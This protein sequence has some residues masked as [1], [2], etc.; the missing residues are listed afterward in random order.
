MA[1][2]A[3]DE[4]HPWDGLA[5]VLEEIQLARTL[6]FADLH[7]ARQAAERGLARLRPLQTNDAPHDA[8]EAELRLLL[9]SCDRQ[10]GHLESAVRQ[11]HAALKLLAGRWGAPVACE[12]WIGLG[13]C[14]AGSGDLAR[15]LRYSLVGLKTARNT[16]QREEQA[17]ALDALG[18]IYA[19]SGDTGEALR[20]LQAAADMA[21]ESGNGRRQCSVLNNVAMAL[22]EAGKL[23]PA[24]AAARDALRLADDNGMAVMRPNVVDTLAGILVAL[25]SMDE[26]EGLLT[27]AV[28]EARKGPATKVLAELLIN[29]AAVKQASGD[30]EQAAALYAEASG[31]AARIASPS[32]ALRCHRRLAESFAASHRW[33][34]AYREFRQYH[35][36]HDSIA[37]RKSATQLALVRIADELDSL[38]GA[39]EPLDDSGL[40]ELGAMEVVLAR[41]QARE[42][43]LAEAKDAAHAAS[44]AKSRFL[45]QMSHDLRTPLNGILGMAH[46]LTRTPLT[47]TQ[48]RYC[49]TLLSTGKELNEL[50]TRILEHAR[51][52]PG[53]T[54]AGIV[55]FD[56][57]D[58]A[59]A[60]V[61]SFTAA[62]MARGLWI[63][64][65]I[66]P[67][68]PP[69]LQG[70]AQRIEQ[71]LDLLVDHVLKFTAKGSVE[72]EVTLLE[73]PAGD[74]RTWLRFA[75]RDTGVGIDAEPAP[76]EGEASAQ[77]DADAGSVLAT[78][79]TLV[80][81]L[82][83]E[84]D[85]T[86]EPSAGPVFWIAVPL[87]P[88][89]AGP[90]PR[91]IHP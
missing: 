80:R 84:I 1:T 55:D 35:A 89:P 48:A 25:G 52:E 82:G 24:L 74:P 54:V 46:L 44:A 90:S 57:A 21:R 5:P 78:G 3:P 19:M 12:G 79:R 62:A 63:G 85:C 2:A 23:T 87:S 20:H 6:R 75:V 77:R 56:P 38:E 39:L 45:S 7:Q 32:L 64:C 33:Q 83:G 66:D 60:V 10:C 50:V 81:L 4:G 27:P 91:S 36:L 47:E 53:L 49:R 9:G 26:A 72:L 29:L 41:L 43:E 58:L 11:F 8:C 18:S 86:R 59:A 73:R 14:Y 17:H 71:V 61:D 22:L 70:E 31:V 28:S 37:G 65:R 76:A 67:G 16:G 30:P 34:E 40:T 42:R 15:A 88:A 69:R 51:I 68:L 13:W